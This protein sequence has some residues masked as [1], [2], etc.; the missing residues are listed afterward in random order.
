MKMYLS[1]WILLFDFNFIQDQCLTSNLD[2][3]HQD[4]LW[5]SVSPAAKQRTQI[6]TRWLQGAQGML[7]KWSGCFRVKSN[8][9]GREVNSKPPHL[10]V[11]WRTCILIKV[12]KLIFNSGGTITVRMEVSMGTKRESEDMSKTTS[13]RFAG[14]TQGG[15]WPEALTPLPSRAVEICL[16]VDSAGQRAETSA[17]GL[18]KG[19]GCFCLIFKIFE[20]TDLH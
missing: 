17:K 15:E 7:T 10:R 4:H 12:Q 18:S 6:H 1:L 2:F 16:W 5:I 14:W 8:L 20:T 3:H 9:H 13:I 19:K 11:N